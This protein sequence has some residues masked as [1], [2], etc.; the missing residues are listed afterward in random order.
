MPSTAPV[1]AVLFVLLASALAHPSPVPAESAAPVQRRVVSLAPSLTELVWALGFGGRMVGRSDACDHPPEAAA[2]PVAGAFGRP[3]LEQIEKLGPDLVLFTDLERPA[4]A[5]R[6]RALGPTCLVLPCESW[7]GLLEAAEQLGRELGETEAASAW[8]RRMRDRRRALD[9][10]VGSFYA[11]RPRPRVYVEVWGD[12]LTTV[13]EGSFLDDIVTLAG[14]RNIG[15]RLRSRYAYVN[16]EWV[17]KEDPD[18]I[19]LAYMLSG[20]TPAPSAIGARPGWAGLRAIRTGAVCGGIRPELL[21]RP[22]PRI[23]DGAEALSDCL[24]KMAGPG[25]SAPEPDT[26]TRV[27]PMEIAR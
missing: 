5:E 18:V 11:G 9:Q 16:P 7:A 12:P 17:L 3:S 10:R 1:R 2:L 15:A 22:G 4:L 13:G 27:T 8:V 14:G 24:M 26:R 20:Q 21:L 25:S 23:I 6:I 19:V